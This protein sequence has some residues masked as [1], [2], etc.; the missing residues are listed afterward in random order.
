MVLPKP[1]PRALRKALRPR[2][3]HPRMV[4]LGYHPP[5]DAPQ[6]DR[7]DV[8]GLVLH[9][10]HRLP[11]HPQLGRHTPRRGSVDPA[12]TEAFLLTPEIR[13]L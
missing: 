5:R 1:R 6:V 2:R 8:L 12:C 11:V 10:D 13:A 9:R 4:D 7:A 3:A